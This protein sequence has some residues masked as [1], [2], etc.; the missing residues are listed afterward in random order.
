MNDIIKEL[1]K[2]ID[3]GKVNEHLGKLPKD[4]DSASSTPILW[5]R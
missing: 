3:I 5:A 4:K 2:D 1:L